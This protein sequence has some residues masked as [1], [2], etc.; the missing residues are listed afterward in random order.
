MQALPRQPM[1]R[2]PPQFRRRFTLPS[3]RLRG[4]PG[5]IGVLAFALSVQP[6]ALARQQTDT[7]AKPATHERRLARSPETPPSA[8]RA[9]PDAEASSSC[10][11]ARVLCAEG[12]YWAGASAARRARRARKNVTKIL[13]HS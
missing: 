13:Y 2:R 5:W 4:V 7:A 3:I 11:I 6:L 9:K 8:T 12:V 1:G 10:S